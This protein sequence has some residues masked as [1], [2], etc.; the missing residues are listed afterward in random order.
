MCGIVGMIHKESIIRVL[1][2]ALKRLEYRG[3]D[4]A[5]IAFFEKDQLSR[6]RALG[7]LQNLEADL[8]DIQATTGMGHTRWATHGEPS[9]KNAHPHFSHQ[10]AIVHNGIVE[11]FVPLKARLQE[12]GYVFSSD[13][14]T[15]VIAHL[16]N[17]ILDRVIGYAG[18]GT[19][20]DSGAQQ[21]SGADTGSTSGT[22]VDSGAQQGSGADTGSTSG[23]GVDSG[24]QQGSGADT[25]STSGTGV[26][27]GAQQGSGA[28][29][30]AQSASQSYDYAYAYDYA[31]QD[32]MDGFIEAINQ[33]EGNFAIA[34]MV[35]GFPQHMFVARRGT[36]PLL[37]GKGGRGYS[38][39]SDALGLVD[40]SDRIGYLESDTCAW[41]GVDSVQVYDFFG[42]PL[43]IKWE[44]PHLQHQDYHQ[45]EY[46]HFMRKEIDEQPDVIARLLQRNIPSL[47]EM[48]PDIHHL[49]LLGCGTSFY[50]AWVGKYMLE[51]RYTVSLELASEFSYRKPK[52]S[53]GVTLALSQSG[54]TADTL[55][56]VAYAQAQ[57]QPIVSLVNAP[58]S[59]L[60]RLSDHV[61][62]MQ[63]GPE[64]GVA[65]TKAF[66]AQLWL[67]F[68]LAGISPQ[69]AENLPQTMRETLSL[70]AEIA[71]WAKDLSGVPSILYMGRGASYPIAL[72]GALKMKELA[73]IHAEGLAA[74]ELKHGSLALVDAHMPIVF[75]A[76][77]D[78]VFEKSLGN[79]H[80]IIARKGQ[81][82]VIT[83]AHGASK[84][85]T[86][87]IQKVIVLPD[88]PLPMFNPFLQA[89]V[90]Q[91]L[92]Y[93]TA[94]D[95]G[96]S[97]DK[98]RNLAKS[99]T[100]E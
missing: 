3:Y 79:I 27:S 25:A 74:G 9:V 21:G 28:D 42:K 54:E 22:G 41:I 4:S 60:A 97:I 96:C 33:L 20:A 86:T 62:D 61:W 93:Y 59:S 17:S 38:I 80:E 23:T 6:Y 35:K 44:L 24:A 85:P 8:P 65:S 5:G 48:Y 88:A 92:A 73:Y 94:L 51:N 55:K 2:P 50:A 67:L 58:H 43:E 29:S 57:G 11:N 87:G 75:L 19:G 72:E 47:Q 69:Q 78:D 49:S 39:S 84:L 31:L 40:V 37:I 46:A 15:E 71:C 36:P 99:V 1:L 76:P 70:S 14:D 68:A 66:T 81:L 95:R 30:G 56:S 34:C 32:V 45:G 82:Y 91:M 16:V 77:T 90:L 26:D 98:P 83:N 100:V 18:A 12:K 64:I 89:L 10:V 7:V 63:A 53:P 52:M 13:T